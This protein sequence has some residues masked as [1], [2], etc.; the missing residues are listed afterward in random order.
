M[1]YA[2]RLCGN[3]DHRRYTRPIEFILED[4]DDDSPPCETETEE[5]MEKLL[6]GN[7]YYEA[8]WIQIIE[9]S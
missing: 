1:F 6:E 5:E 4:V 7:A 2:V 9:I 3:P 8:G